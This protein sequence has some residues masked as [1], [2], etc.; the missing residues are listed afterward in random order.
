MDMTWTE[1]LSIG[2]A[3]LDFDHKKLI[4]LVNYIDYVTNAKDSFELLRALKLFECYMKRHSIKEEQFAQAINLPFAMHKVAHQ[5]IQAEIELT[6]Y[7]LARNGTTNIFVMAD[8]PKFLW[9]CLIKH[10][11]EE[12]MLMKP[13]L[14]THPYDFKFDEAHAYS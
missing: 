14:Q 7:E 5:N 2:N 11:T 10:I 3:V 12:D 6:E 4:S 13:A 1:K 9:D 8:Y